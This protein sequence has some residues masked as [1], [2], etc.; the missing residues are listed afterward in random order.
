M[1]RHL[2]SDVPEAVAATAASAP[3]GDAKEAGEPSLAAE[4]L[5]L[6]L[7]LAFVVGFVAMVFVFLFGVFQAPDESMDPAFREGDLVVYY[8][9]Q[10]DYAAGDVIVVN[11]GGTEEIRRVIAVAG[12]VVDFSEDGLMVNGYRQS[13]DRIYTDTLPFT[14]GI[15]YPVTVGEGQVF[16]MGD[17]RPESKDSRLYGTVDIETGTEGEVMT[18]VRRRNF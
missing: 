18:V 6:A 5:L 11:D 4:L 9:L 10:K 3:T 7:K 8:R 14:E 15:T 1:S 2:P 17:N 13:E 16:V 12:D